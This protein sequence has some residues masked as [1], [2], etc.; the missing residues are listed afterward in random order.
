MYQQQRQWQEHQEEFTRQQEAAGEGQKA[1]P[2]GEQR[3][4]KHIR[5]H[6]GNDL[7]DEFDDSHLWLHGEG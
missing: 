5:W 4:G 1:E 2:Q 6:E 7:T 3:S